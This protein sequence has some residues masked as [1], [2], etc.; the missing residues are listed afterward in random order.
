MKV[1]YREKKKIKFR[2]SFVILFIIASFAVCFTFYMKEDF[3]ITEEMFEDEA[4]AVVYIEPVGQD[5]GIVN[6]VPK[7]VTKEKDYYDSAVFIGSTSLAG[8]SDYGY[9]EAENMLLSDSIKLS[10]FNS[11]ILSENGVE[12][13]I[14]DSVINRNCKNVYIMLGLYELGNVDEANM[15][16]SLEA[17]IDDVKGRNPDITIYLMSVLPVPAEIEATVAAN[18]DIDAYNSLLLRFADKVKVGYLDVNTEFKGNDG[19]LSS[20]AA[21]IN[22]VRLKKETYSELSDYILSHIVEQ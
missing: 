15:F 2:I 14:A 9:V 8:L 7:S 1:T 3:V 19:K 17:F 6:P 21:E 18:T 11:V 13:T 4:E 22:G 20:S 12:S 10:N 5:K 16:S